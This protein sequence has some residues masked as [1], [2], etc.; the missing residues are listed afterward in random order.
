PS[1]V[2][3]AERAE[4]WRRPGVRAALGLLALLLLL[5]LGAQ[6]GYVYRDVIGAR[7]PLL[8]PLLAAA[9]QPLACSVGAPRAIEHLTVDSSGLVRVEKSNLYKLS[10]TLRNRDDVDLR[11]PAIDLAL[12]DSRGK[13]LARRVLNPSDLGA[14][15]DALAAGRELA[16]Q[17]TL[18]SAT[19]PVA[20]YTV[21]L[22][23]P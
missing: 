9:C 10:V 4:R 13:L 11:L 7:A 21:E 6:A 23:Y 15:R 19:A 5:T 12:T 22:F 18:Q 14:P 17:A 3:R 8:R 2:R 20:G 16:L 1:F